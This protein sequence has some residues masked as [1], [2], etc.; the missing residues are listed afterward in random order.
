VSEN[1]YETTLKILCSLQHTIAT[2]SNVNIFKSSSSRQHYNSTFV[3]LSQV[4]LV[5]EHVH[6]VILSCDISTCG[7]LYATFM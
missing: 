4:I 7:D 2:K 1:I 5:Q 3:L 6:A